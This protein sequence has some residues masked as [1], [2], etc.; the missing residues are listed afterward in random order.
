MPRAASAKCRRAQIR[1][2]IHIS[3]VSKRGR[4]ILDHP[5]YLVEG[6]RRAETRAQLDNAGA[7]GSCRSGMKRDCQSGERPKS[8]AL[9]QL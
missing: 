8:H 2:V 5:G 1:G 9:A 6:G 7:C 3:S 4:L